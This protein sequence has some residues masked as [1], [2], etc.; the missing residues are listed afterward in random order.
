MVMQLS[1]PPLINFRTRHKL[2]CP[3]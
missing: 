2:S 1:S 3:G